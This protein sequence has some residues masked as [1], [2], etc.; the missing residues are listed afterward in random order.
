MDQ[1]EPAG[2][3]GNMVAECLIEDKKEKRKEKIKKMDGLF[4]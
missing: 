1:R 2:A 3:N 4:F